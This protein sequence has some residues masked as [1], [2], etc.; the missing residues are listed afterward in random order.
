METVKVDIQKL[1][2]L[3]DRIAQ[4]IDALN[5]VRMSAHGIQHTPQAYGPVPFGSTYGAYPTPQAGFVQPFNPYTSPYT[6]SPYAGSFLGSQL[7]VPFTTSPFVGGLQHAGW[8]TPYTTGNGISHTT[9]DP[10]W[11][12]RTGQL[13]PFTQTPVSIT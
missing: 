1:Q 5:Q 13:F 3:N 4:M 11:Q 2:L 8:P 9:W 10:T 7:P 6:T 12:W